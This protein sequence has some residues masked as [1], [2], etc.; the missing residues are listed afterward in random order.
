MDEENRIE[1]SITVAV[2][3][4][5]TMGCG[6][7]TSALAHGFQVVVADFDEASTDAGI[8]QIASRIERYAETG[9][10]PE[11]AVERG[12]RPI[13]DYGEL[14]EGVSLVI[15]AVPESYEVKRP[16]LAALSLGC[17]A[18]IATNTSALSVDELATSVVDPHRFLGVHFFNPAELIPGVEI[19]RGAVTDDEAVRLAA[20]ILGRLSKHPSVVLDSPGFIANRIQFALFAECARCL[21]EGLASAEEIDQIVRTTFGFRLGAYGPFKI[22]DMAGLDVYVSIL[23]TLSAAFGDRFDPSQT[24][25]GTVAA[26]KTGTKTR[27]GFFD[28]TASEVEA[29]GA[30]RD[31][32][33][34]GLLGTLGL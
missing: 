3:G 32:T 18:V 17:P 4:L 33:Y 24:L 7:A 22:A 23:E 25:L 16:V 15:E 21:E 1:S 29:L 19:V 14:R 27:G 9:D 10:V 12:L 13:T 28:Y 6:I 5:G 2:V 20:T 30:S 8:R 26:G 34:R 11:R 31:E